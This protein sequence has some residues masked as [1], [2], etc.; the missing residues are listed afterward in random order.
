MN[1][2]NIDKIS[3]YRL[4]VALTAGFLILIGCA[5]VLQPFIPSLMLALIFSLT[6]WPAYEWMDRKLGGRKV[7]AAALMTLLLSVCFIVPLVILGT[8]VAENFAKMF[9][10]LV[11]TLNTHT[12]EPPVWLSKI[13]VMGEDLG[14]MWKAY[15]GDRE[16]VLQTLTSHAATISQFVLVV[17][18]AI[19]K[20]LIDL[21]LGVI[22]T[23]F[24]FRYGSQAS[25]RIRN[26]IDGFAGDRGQYLLQLSK[27]TMIGVIYGVLGTAIAQGAFAALGF[28]IAGLPGPAFLGLLT[29]FV[30]IIPFGPPLVWVP[31]TLWL[32]AEQDYYSAIFM[33]IYG[34]CV[35]STLDNIIRPYFISV[36]SNLHILLVLM[37][38]IGGILAFGFIGLFI[39]PVL[40]AIAMTLIMEW[41]TSPAGKS[42]LLDNSPPV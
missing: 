25:E 10:G 7:K 27:K 13:P 28:W 37:G 11:V 3:L 36:G 24:F 35:I 30:S 22:I 12:Q 39:G 41:S 1:F 18:A 8:S 17:G 32:I 4:L 42:K 29:F 6:T 20:G 33:A 34:A 38:I 14:D 5:I 26:L 15:A 19:G 21:S 31:A 16:K 40:L 9:S 2:D 23:Y